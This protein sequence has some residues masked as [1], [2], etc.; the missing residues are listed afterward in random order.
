VGAFYYLRV[1][2]MMYFDAPT[3]ELEVR[4]DSGA[5]L[6]LGVNGALLLAL[7]I[8]PGPLLDLCADAVRR[9]LGG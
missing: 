4:T 2:R 5:R 8:L 3:T 7:G 6:T 1:V 9:A